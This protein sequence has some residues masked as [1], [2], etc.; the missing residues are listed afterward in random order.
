MRAP[1]RPPTAPESRA[2]R[3]A[4]VFAGAGLVL[5]ACAVYANSFSGP[6]IFDDLDSIPQNPTIRSLVTSLVPPGGGVTVMGRPLLNLS[7]A[8]NYALSGDHVWSYHALNLLI[9]IG[10][11]LTLFGIVRRTLAHVG[12]GRRTPPDFGSAA[13]G[14]AALQSEATFVAFAV[15]LL[16]TLHPLQT[17]SVTYIVQRAESLMGLCYLLTL[18][19]FIRGAGRQEGF[20]FA[21]TGSTSSPRADSAS[22]PQAGSKR[23]PPDNTAGHERKAKT[24]VGWFALAF[25]F[26][27]L[28]M[29]TKEVMV[30]APLIVLLYDRTFLAGSFRAAWRRRGWVHLVLAATWIPLAVL[31]LQAANRGGSAGFGVGVGFWSYVATQFQ[32]VSH[33]LWLSVWPHPLI[34]DYGVQWVT[35]VG[36]VA[37]YVAGVALLVG[38]TLVALVRRPALGFLGVSFFAILAPTSLVPVARQTLAEHRMYLSLAPVMVLV[39]LAL[40]SWLGRRGWF[41]LAAAAVGLG[42]LTVQRNTVYHSDVTILTDTVAKRPGNAFARNNYGNVMLWAGRPEEALAHY[43]EAIRLEPKYATDFYYNAGNALAQLGRLPEAIARYEQALRAKPNTPDAQTALG[44]ALEDAGRGDEAVVHYEQALRLDSK[45]TDAHDRLG[46]ALM[47]AGRLPDAIAHFEQ[48]LRINPA[49]SDVHNNLGNALRATGRL[50]EALAHY[51]E[52]LRL[53]PEF[54]AAHH[55]LANALRD[56]DRLPEA[57]GHYEQ[58]VRLNSTSPEI[59]NNFGIALLMSERT[60]DAIAHFERALQLNPN[61]AQVHLNL[62]MALESIGRRAEASAHY[63]SARRLGAAVPPSGN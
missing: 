22:S 28:G 17:E 19:C 16:W 43:E 44:I 29:A 41:V 33:Y 14:D 18:Y 27:L 60:P 21:S 2:S 50:P 56:A 30:S 26:C 8:L 48:A 34:I 63:E 53:R 55:N 38:A 13:F 61:L 51:A 4:T 5:A 52:A 49:L 15:A 37:P 1:P 54:A 6:F 62:A 12:Q 45:Y 59:Q 47:K 3:R 32:A 25:V 9:H 46:V 20:G 36:D 35:S 42:W 58:A 10:A 39:V 23:S 40:C 24:G 31:V 7:F 57:L 11:G